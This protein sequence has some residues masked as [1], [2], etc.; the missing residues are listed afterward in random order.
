[1]RLVI[2]IGKSS[3]LPVFLGFFVEE[4]SHPVDRV[5]LVKQAEFLGELRIILHILQVTDGIV[6]VDAW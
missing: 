1:M 3:K 6:V 2:A 5:T 4:T